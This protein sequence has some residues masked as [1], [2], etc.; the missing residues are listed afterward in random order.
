MSFSDNCNDELKENP[1]WSPVRNGYDIDNE[2]TSDLYTYFLYLKQGEKDYIDYFK[3]EE[4]Y[5]KAKNNNSPTFYYYELLYNEDNTA[6]I[7]EYE[8]N[9]GNIYYIP[10]NLFL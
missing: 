3:I 10:N 2:L 4:S 1:T 6:F 9:L 7:K 8:E 5:L